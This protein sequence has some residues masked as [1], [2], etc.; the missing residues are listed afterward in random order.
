MD[1]I[2]PPAAPPQ[3]TMLDRMMEVCTQALATAAAASNAT[4]KTNDD[5]KEEDANEAAS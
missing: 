2:T 1:N 5:Q 4:P 3:P